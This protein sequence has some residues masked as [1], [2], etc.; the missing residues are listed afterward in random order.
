MKKEYKIRTINITFRFVF[1]KSNGGSV[2]RLYGIP[3]NPE[4]EIIHG[5]PI[6]DGDG[7][8]DHYFCLFKF[9]KI[10]SIE[11]FKIRKYAI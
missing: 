9:W 5:Y 10:F 7:L 11:N 3:N 1:V 4:L 2:M 8:C 6:K